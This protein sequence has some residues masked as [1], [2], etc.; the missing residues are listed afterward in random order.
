MDCGDRAR[1]VGG[2]FSVEYVPLQGFKR[3]YLMTEIAIM[4]FYSSTCI[5]RA[6]DYCTAAGLHYKQLTLIP[7]FARDLEIYQKFS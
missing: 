1:E 4:R 6:I 3:R 5:L 7:N 2:S